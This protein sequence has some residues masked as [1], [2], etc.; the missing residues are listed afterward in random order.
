MPS[1]LRQANAFLVDQARVLDRVDP[2]T[3]RV[4][5][6]VRAM[7]MGSDFEAPEMRFLRNRPQF[8]LVQ[9]RLA[10]LRIARK[11][12]AGGADLDDLRAVLALFAHALLESLRV[13]RHAGALAALKLGGR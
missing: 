2:R 11:D 8:V 10:R 6:A 9:L 1:L 4:L 13:V 7:R 12:P 3:N 5:D